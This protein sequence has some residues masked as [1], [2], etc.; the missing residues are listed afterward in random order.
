MVWPINKD[1]SRVTD[2]EGNRIRKLKDKKKKQTEKNFG[3]DNKKR[4]RMRKVHRRDDNTGKTSEGIENI[5]KKS[6]SLP[7]SKLQRV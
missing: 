1:S 2:G 3:K 5:D 7:N 6:G 4:Y